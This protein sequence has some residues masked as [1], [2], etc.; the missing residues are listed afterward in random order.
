[1]P[2]AKSYR[3]VIYRLIERPATGAGIDIDETLSF[4]AVAS[5][6]PSTGP[7]AAQASF[8][9]G[10]E[11]ATVLADLTRCT[12][13][14]IGGSE[15]LSLV[16]SPVRSGSQ[17]LRFN[18]I[19]F[20]I[21]GG[22]GNLYRSFGVTG[23]T[24]YFR[25]YLRPVS[26]AS[27]GADG[28][29]GIFS[30]D[31]TYYE[32]F[33]GIGLYDG[34]V[35]RY[36][37]G[38]RYGNQHGAY[39]LGPTL[40]PNTWYRFEARYHLNGG[41]RY[42]TFNEAG[43]MIGDS[44]DITPNPPTVVACPSSFQG[45]L[46]GTSTAYAANFEVYFDDVAFRADSSVTWD[47]WIGPGRV[48]LAV[49]GPPVILAEWTPVGSVNHH[50]NVDGAPATYSD[51]DYNRSFTVG[52]RDRYSLLRRTSIPATAPITFFSLSGRA[53]RTAGDSR[54]RLSLLGPGFTEYLAPQWQ[55]GAPQDPPASS[56]PA[57]SAG[58]VIDSA[59]IETV[60]QYQVGYQL[61]VGGGA[62]GCDIMEVVVGLNYVA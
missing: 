59:P 20:G 17:A 38:D 33:K 23:P 24:H 47:N 52:Q 11:E 34:L 44:G 46:L 18:N 14:G 31:N 51:A 35:V 58:L 25:F 3:S 53:R 55:P 61:T 40:A 45:F 21:P 29:A 49:P 57:T 15:F 43:A 62:N 30:V 27:R 7:M 54:L 1:M 19:I 10:F 16:T 12:W 9:S 56:D 32:F 42:K 5:Y 13:N 8:L 41:R 60:D 22:W 28:H 4:P 36:D 48:G 50:E 39:I 6:R 2:V 37:V 26:V